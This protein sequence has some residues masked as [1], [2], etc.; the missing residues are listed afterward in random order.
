MD[1]WGDEEKLEEEKEKRS[2]NKEKAK[3]KKYEKR[4]KGFL[5]FNNNI[6]CGAAWRLGL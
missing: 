6:Y 3:R 4:I 5:F 2:D 1:V